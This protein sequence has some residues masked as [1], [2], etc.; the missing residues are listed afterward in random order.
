MILPRRASF[1]PIVCQALNK[2][3]LGARIGTMAFSDEQER[4]LGNDKHFK[5][6][7]KAMESDNVGQ[8]N[9]FAASLGPHFRADLRG[10]DL[11]GQNLSGINLR[12]A[13]LDDVCFDQCDLSFADLTGAVLTGAT[14]RESV[15]KSTKMKA[16]VKVKTAKAAVNTAAETAESP[17]IRRRR[18]LAAMQEQA[19]A[20]LVERKKKQEAQE[21]LLAKVKEKNRGTMFSDPDSDR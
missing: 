1:N 8:W 15:L 5:V 10:A 6:L 11:T 2:P 7:K 17:E 20:L 16:P 14:F 4:F 18:R 21:A 13:R 9:E 19:E 12:G 3:P